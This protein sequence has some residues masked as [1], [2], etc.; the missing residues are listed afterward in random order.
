MLLERKLKKIQKKRPSIPCFWKDTCMEIEAVEKIFQK[1]SKKSEPFGAFLERY[2]F[3]TIRAKYRLPERKIK[4]VRKNQTVSRFFRK[5]LGEGKGVSTMAT[6]IFL[7][8]K[9]KKIP[10]MGRFLERYLFGDDRDFCWIVKKLKKVQNFPATLD[11]FWKILIRGQKNGSTIFP[12]P[13]RKKW[14]K[15][16]KSDHFGIFVEDTCL[17]RSDGNFNNNAQ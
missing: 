16:K 13:G 4:K 5:I 1:K 7:Q 9:F 3:G 17:E 6:T 8:K 10:P 11:F 12:M 14:E 2:L 15:W